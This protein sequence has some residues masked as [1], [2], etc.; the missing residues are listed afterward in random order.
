M[1]LYCQINIKVLQK[2]KIL[3]I[4]VLWM[5]F[6]EEL[7]LACGWS[8]LT[9]F[10]RVLIVLGVV[11]C[12]AFF[13]F[14][15]NILPDLVKVGRYVAS[16]SEDGLISGDGKGDY[17]HG[18]DGVSIQVESVQYA[19][20]DLTGHLMNEPNPVRGT[21]VWFGKA[22]WM[23]ESLKPIGPI[24]PSD[25]YTL[26]IIVHVF[27]ENRSI[28]PTQMDIGTPYQPYI[29][30]TVYNMEAGVTEEGI[31]CLLVRTPIEGP[32]IG[33]YNHILNLTGPTPPPELYEDGYAYFTRT[34]GKTWVLDVDAWFLTLRARPIPGT[35]EYEILKDY[36]KL[37]IKMTITQV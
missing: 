37:S 9:R 1:E 7:I 4:H 12:I 15:F 31:V 18:E 2:L 8:V 34:E 19:L 29:S 23:D 36:V 30:I 21:Y 16:I 20:V 17:V 10:K 25:R 3:L 22:S 35:S 26:T 32:Q 14:A 28:I 11:S 6:R 13:Y 5:R 27:V 33:F 24:L